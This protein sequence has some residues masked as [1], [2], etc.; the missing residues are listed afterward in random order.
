MSRLLA[1]LIG[2]GVA[3]GLVFVAAPAAASETTAVDRRPSA[4]STPVTGEA[5][6]A[7]AYPVTCVESGGQVSCTPDNPSLVKP[8]QCFL[9]VFYAGSQATVCTTYEEHAEAIRSAGGK[10]VL[11][12]TQP[13]RRPTEAELLAGAG[14]ALSLAKEDMLKLSIGVLAYELLC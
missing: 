4:T 7:P 2:I 3:L 8:Q 9:G 1:V 6:S 10:L 11:R 12:R 13:G 14:D 5:W